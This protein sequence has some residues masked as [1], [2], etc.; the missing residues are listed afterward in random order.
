MNQTF[1]SIIT[2]NYNNSKLTFDF[3]KS[4]RE[5]FPTAIPYE[6]IIID[7]GSN[8]ESYIELENHVNKLSL[9]SIT[10]HRSNI[11]LGFGGGNMLGAQF[12]KG[13]YLAFIN[14]DII[15][16][17]DCFTPLIKFLQENK[18]VGVCTPQQYLGNNKPT[19]GLDYFHGIR[20]EI[21]GRSFVEKFFEKDRVKRNDFPYTK[22]SKADFI[23][24]CFM[25]FYAEKFNEVGGFDTN[26]F[27]YFEE[28]DICYRLKQKG[29]ESYVIPSTKFIHLHG[30][31]TTQS[32]A[33]KQELLISKLYIYRKNYSFLKYKILQIII[34]KK[35]LFKSLL[36]PS[37]FQL[38]K[39]AFLGGHL[40]YSLKQKQKINNL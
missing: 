31:S 20:K 30:A 8:K 22:N 2:I 3:L 37:C 21:F 13:N 19:S 27:L 25:F 14:N 36:K 34:S 4:L 39:I 5:N 28:M 33:I 6:V 12:A 7:N 29:Y 26:I 9:E 40:K 24:G 38:F 10:L 32:M 1:V 16:I 17:E 18:R 11:N 35:L 15:F 23:Q